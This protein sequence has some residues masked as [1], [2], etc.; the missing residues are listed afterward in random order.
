M[1]CV[2]VCV[3]VNVVGVCAS[4]LAQRWSSLGG[5]KPSPLEYS[6]PPGGWKPSPAVIHV[7][8]S[9]S[10]NISS[11]GRGARA[12]ARATS[13][14]D[15]GVGGWGRWLCEYVGSAWSSLGGWK[16]SPLEYSRPPGGWKPS[17]AVIHVRSSRNVIIVLGQQYR[18]SLQ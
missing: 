7:R 10:A 6:R 15:V 9:R 14:D 11:R 1:V 17:P 2:C 16:P 5:W 4:M 13:K 12:R 3:D 8:S 18:R